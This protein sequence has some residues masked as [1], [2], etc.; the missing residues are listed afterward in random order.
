MW[1]SLSDQLLLQP[2]AHVENILNHIFHSLLSPSQTKNDCVFGFVLFVFPK[3]S[4]LCG[5]LFNVIQLR[6]WGWCW[7][8]WSAAASVNRQIITL[9]LRVW[10]EWK[11]Q[12]CPSHTCKSD[13]G[14]V[15]SLARSLQL[16]LLCV[17]EATSVCVLVIIMNHSS[18]V[19]LRASLC[20]EDLGFVCFPSLLRSGSKDSNKFNSAR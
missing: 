2:S 5:F 19:C 14:V 8:V 13:L 18:A 1:T 4:F 7:S 17:C 6:E 10:S 11:V 3:A 12:I 15:L 20:S 16:L 9:R